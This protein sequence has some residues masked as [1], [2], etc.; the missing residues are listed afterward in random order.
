LLAAASG[1]PCCSRLVALI[2]IRGNCIQAQA[3]FLFQHAP[4]PSPSLSLPPETVSGR[5]QARRARVQPEHFFPPQ[6]HAELQPIRTNS[7]QRF[8]FRSLG[9]TFWVKLFGFNW[10]QSQVE[11]ILASSLRPVSVQLGETSRNGRLLLFSAT[12]GRLKRR[13]NRKNWINL[14][15]CKNF[16]RFLKDFWRI[17][18]RK[19][20]HHFC[21]F[22]LGNLSQT[23]AKHLPQT[24][25]DV[26]EKKSINLA[27]TTSRKFGQQV[28]IEWAKKVAP[29]KGLHQ[30]AAS[31]R[32][33]SVSVG[34][35]QKVCKTCRQ[36]AGPSCARPKAATDCLRRQMS[37][38]DSPPALIS[39]GLSNCGPNQIKSN[40][41]ARTSKFSEFSEDEN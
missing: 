7:V 37:T 4:P 25:A 38:A 10:R 19:F 34:L 6:S 23:F 12:F 31:G 35:A 8:A 24:K 36:C 15:D 30:K 2:L 33:V 32:K 3:Y 11:I 13:K 18:F 17:F 20:G 28:S 41:K 14:Q 26:W 29:E 39:F 16:Q 22:K 5:Q 40:P 27:R 9:S 1:W 21:Q